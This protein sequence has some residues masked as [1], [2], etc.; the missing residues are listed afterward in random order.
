M[1][2]EIFGSRRISARRAFWI[3]R[4]ENARPVTDDGEAERRR[5]D[6]RRVTFGVRVFL[7][8]AMEPFVDRRVF[9]LH[10]FTV[11]LF[12]LRTRRTPRSAARSPG[13][14]QPGRA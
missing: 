6:G 4:S 14:V 10:G 7:D 9:L 8:C 11:K 5:G 3:S 13:R 2:A 1:T 12:D